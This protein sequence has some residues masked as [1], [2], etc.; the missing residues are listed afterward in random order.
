MRKPKKL[1]PSGDPENKVDT[2]LSL[3][4]PLEITDSEATEALHSLGCA[5]LTRQGLR[6]LAVLGYQV[7]GVGAYRTVQGEAVLSRIK[8]VE[9]MDKIYASVETG[10]EGAVANLD[11]LIE[12]AP[13]VAILQKSL[14]DS[15]KI[16]KE[17][18]DSQ[19]KESGY[20]P[21]VPPCGPESFPAGTVIMADNVTIS[22]QNN[23]EKPPIQV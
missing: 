9:F 6:A 19:N 23:Q 1:L 4:E 18:I 16:S 3:N 15:L 17:I 2:K 7:E 10:E 14:N 22:Q 11:K 21:P 5:K 12:V 20:I 8:L 13:A